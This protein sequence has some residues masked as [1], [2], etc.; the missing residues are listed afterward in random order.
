MSLE[1]GATIAKYGILS[2]LAALA[3]PF[4]YGAMSMAFGISDNYVAQIIQGLTAISII[5]YFVE[6]GGVKSGVMAA[7]GMGAGIV[8]ASVVKDVGFAA[9]SAAFGWVAN[10]IWD[11]I[12][13]GFVFG[14][15]IGALLAINP[16]SAVLTAVLSGITALGF[17]AIASLGSLIS[18][19]IGGALEGIGK[20]LSEGYRALLAPY[21]GVFL[22]AL[23]LSVV[24]VMAGFAAAFLVGLAIGVIIGAII[25]L[26]LSALFG[27][28][29]IFSIISLIGY[30]VGL[31]LAIVFKPFKGEDVSETIVNIIALIIAPYMA[32][33]LYTAGYGLLLSRLTAHTGYYLIGVSTLY[34]LLVQRVT[35]VLRL[36]FG[37]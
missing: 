21:F 32:P 25:S 37:G 27:V 33:A 12:F 26:I 36:I 6:H 24:V 31:L 4:V 14:I 23:P 10:A 7:L 17:S 8:T 22:V 9:L 16:L 3:P 20:R 13:K 28:P 11:Y 5:I 1:L 18:K 2:V 30:V 34:Y 15:V 19:A 29:F 35:D